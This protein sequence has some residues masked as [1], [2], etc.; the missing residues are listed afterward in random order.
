MKTGDEVINL[1]GRVQDTC[2]G[3]AVAA[4]GLVE[5]WVTMAD[6]VASAETEIGA[7]PA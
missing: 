2:C 1:A 3:P 4:A 7:S 6:Y 5:A